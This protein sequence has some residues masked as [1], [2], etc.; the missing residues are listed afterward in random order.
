MPIPETPRSK[1]EYDLVSFDSRVRE[2]RDLLPTSSYVK[3]S[4]TLKP[5]NAAVAR[6]RGDIKGVDKL[7]DDAKSKKTRA[8]IFLQDSVRS[9]Q[10]QL[11]EIAYMWQA[12]LEEKHYVETEAFCEM[13]EKVGQA[14]YIHGLIV[15]AVEH[16]NQPGGYKNFTDEEMDIERG[17]AVDKFLAEGDQIV[18]DANTE[19]RRK[20]GNAAKLL[21]EVMESFGDLCKLAG[22]P[23][24][25]S[26]TPS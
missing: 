2:V 19:L 13:K 14:D 18:L 15:R 25:N 11:G 24:A 7:I 5:F 3:L 1:F 21:V 22:L 9:M 26:R 23:K 16:N 12:Y 10:K 20:E 8:E 4:E 17:K 6:L